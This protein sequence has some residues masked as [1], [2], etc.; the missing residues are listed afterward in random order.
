[1]LVGRIQKFF[2]ILSNAA[3]IMY[4]LQVFYDKNIMKT[5]AF[6]ESF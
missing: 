1:M 6:R 3:K 4:N 5:S 2:S